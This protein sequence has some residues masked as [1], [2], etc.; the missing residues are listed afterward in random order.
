MVTGDWL[1]ALLQTTDS[2]FPSGA[3]AHSAGLEG[4]VELGVA[5]DLEG[6]RNYI[7]EQLIPGLEHSELPYLRFAYEAAQAGDFALLSE[8]GGEYGAGRLMREAH[9]A[10]LSLGRQRLDMLRRIRDCP[11][12]ALFDAQCASLGGAHLVV[13]AAVQ[14]VAAGIPLTAAQTAFAYAAVAALAASFKLI[15]LGQ[16]AAQTLLTEALE[17]LPRVIERSQQIPREEAGWFNPVLDIATARHETAY[18]RLFIS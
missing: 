4:V 11:L 7:F 18:T 3:Y 8:L 5:G 17:T 13:V 2:G 9:M 16:I 14:A 10:S 6:L 1:G 12:V 15:R